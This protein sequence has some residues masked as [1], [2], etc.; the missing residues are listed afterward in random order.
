MP[1]VPPENC[2]ASTTSANSITITWENGMAYTSIRVQCSDDAGASWYTANLEGGTAESSVHTG[3]TQN[4]TYTY[5]VQGL[6][7]GGWTSHSNE[8]TATCWADTESEATSLVESYGD[9]HTVDN[10][11]FLEKC[12]VSDSGTTDSGVFSDT[13]AETV[14]VIS[15]DFSSQ[16]I[17]PDFRYYLGDSTGKVYEYWD[18]YLSDND[19]AIA[20]YWRSKRLSFNDQYP[21]YENWWKILRGVKL[22]YKDKTADMNVTIY[23]SSDEGVTWS[24][25]MKTIG[26]GSDTIKSADFFFIKHG[27]FFDFK[28]ENSSTDKNF[29]WIGMEVY[30]EP[31]GEYREF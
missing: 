2:V 27:Q 13:F 23:V 24:S 26:T 11:T 6:G 30:F 29:Q 10:E 16:T 31:D 7:A 28:V 19:T 20:S 3:R 8:D 1:D 12:T 25:Q 5:R 9:T 4:V 22:I 21:D 17:H 15:Y 18:D 14:T